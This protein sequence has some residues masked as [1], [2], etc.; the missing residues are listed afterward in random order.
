MPNNKSHTPQL[1]ANLQSSFTAQQDTTTSAQNA[2]VDSFMRAEMVV[3]S[4]THPH[5]PFFKWKPKVQPLNL[6]NIRFQEEG[7]FKGSPYLRFDKLQNRHGVMGEPAPRN[8]ANDDLVTGVLLLCFVLG[9]TA[10]SMS[11]NFILQQLKGLFRL[12]YRRSNVGETADELKYQIFLVVQTAL[13]FSVSYYIYDKEVLGNVYTMATPLLTMGVF[14][15]VFLSY[16]VVKHLL[17]SVVNWVYFEKRNALQWRNTHLFLTSVEGGLLLPSVLLIIYFNLAIQYAL[18]YV[19][20]IVGLIKL[21]SFYQTFVIFFRRINVSL[22][23]ILYFCTLELLPMMAL[24]GV[25]TF[26]GNYLTLNI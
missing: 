18:I 15:A 16:F 6:Q 19:V 4:A 10:A 1:T 5:L 13:I 14:F 21:L 23:I 25:L 26:I 24:I 8:L 12:P 2:E 9:I 22:Q 7:F 11:R 17:Y 20:I 3:D